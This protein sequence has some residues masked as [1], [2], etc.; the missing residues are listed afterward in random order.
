MTAPPTKVEN[1]HSPT[2]EQVK[3]YNIIIHILMA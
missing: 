3:V 1:R 2:L